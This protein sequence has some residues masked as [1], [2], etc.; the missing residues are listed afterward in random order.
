MRGELGNE[1]MVNKLI[2]FLKEVVVELKKVSWGSRKETFSAAISIIVL[3]LF[4]VIIMAVVDFG[5]SRLLG[6]LIR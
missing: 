5:L 2:Q 4:V 1:E 6:L 3:I